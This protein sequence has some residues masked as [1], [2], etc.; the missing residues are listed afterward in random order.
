MLR[1]RNRFFRPDAMIFLQQLDKLSIQKFVDFEFHQT[2]K[3]NCW[4]INMGGGVNQISRKISGLAVGTEQNGKLMHE[5]FDVKNGRKWN[6]SCERIEHPHKIHEYS[7]EKC[8]FF[9]K[10]Y[11]CCETCFQSIFK[12]LHLFA[13]K[14]YVTFF[15]SIHSTLG[16]LA[17]E[18][19]TFHSDLKTPNLIH[20][21]DVNTTQ[22]IPYS[23]NISWCC[24]CIVLFTKTV[25]IFFSF[26]FFF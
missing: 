22:K 24:I 10:Y 15:M 13:Q 26:F 12:Y 9:V 4:R 18:C 5:R 3:I 7:C 20:I 6:L 17:I 16:G 21:H 8:N 14:K 11:I 2:L 23:D 19:H 25:A 1:T